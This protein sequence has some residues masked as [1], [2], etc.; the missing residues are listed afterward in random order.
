MTARQHQCESQLKYM[1]VLSI[2]KNNFISSFVPLCI[3]ANNMVSVCYKYV[4]L[5]ATADDVC[6]HADGCRFGIFD[7]WV[8]GQ[9]FHFRFTISD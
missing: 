6:D 9:Y 4:L 8:E 3:E 7:A 2:R 5:N 1:C